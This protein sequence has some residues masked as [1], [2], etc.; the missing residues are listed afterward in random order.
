MVRES[1]II[2]VSLLRVLGHSAAAFKL[3][4]SKRPSKYLELSQAEGSLISASVSD[5]VVYAATGLEMV[6]SAV[7]Q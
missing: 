6:M 4:H 5:E 1:D 3:R 2:M 7:P